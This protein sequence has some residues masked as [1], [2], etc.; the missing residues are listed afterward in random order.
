MAEQSG[1]GHRLYVDGLNVSGDVN[2]AQLSC[3]RAVQASPAIDK[4][5]MERLLRRG[6]GRL[7]FASLFNDDGAADRANAAG[8]TFH[9]F[10]ALPTSNVHLLYAF[11]ASLGSQCAALSAKQANHDG[12]VGQDGSLTF[13]VEALAAAGVE[14]EFGRMLSAG[15]ITFAD[16][17]ASA[18]T[19]LVE[20]QTT[21][22][23]VAFLQV[24]SIDSGTPTF[25]VE[26]SDDTTDGDDGT[27]A[28]LL[29]LDLQAAG[30]QRKTVTGTV[31]KGLRVGTPTGTYTN[32][33][34]AVGF[35]RGTAEDIVDLS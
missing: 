15:Q 5:G 11:G 34:I 1:L 17:N 19:G 24:E 21:A 18:P 6:A 35:R 27:W 29:T 23:G 25:I 8:S 28:T 14:I 16:E 2:N 33:K 31:E 9:T 7:G 22:G 3:P 32:A 10:S 12:Q 20:A 4:L 13:S 30:A 26:D